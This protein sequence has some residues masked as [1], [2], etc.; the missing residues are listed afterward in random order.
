M[1]DLMLGSFTSAHENL[2]VAGNQGRMSRVGR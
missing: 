1:S 2:A